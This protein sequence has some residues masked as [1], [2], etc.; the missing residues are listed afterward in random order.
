[1][2]AYSFFHVVAYTIH[3]VVILLEGNP[4]PAAS[5]EI[6]VSRSKAVLAVRAAATADADGADDAA[7]TTAAELA[8]DASAATVT[9]IGELG[10]HMQSGPASPGRCG[11]GRRWPSRA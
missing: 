7:V 2:C 5:S 6:S 8:A 1:M 10:F 11:R 9:S 4:I 3:S